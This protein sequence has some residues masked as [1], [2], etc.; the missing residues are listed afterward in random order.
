[1]GPRIGNEKAPEWMPKG[2]R[3]Y[4]RVGSRVTCNPPPVETDEDWLIWAPSDLTSELTAGGFVVEGLPGFYTGN[5]NGNFVS[6]RRAEINAITTPDFEWYRK[7]CRATALAK[8]FNLMLKEDRIALF[9]V[10]LYEVEPEN[11][12]VGSDCGVDLL[13]A[14]R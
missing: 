8:R 2:A 9:Q 7:F 3:A 11:L 5:D 6:F 13:D 1:M 12:A 10:I 14:M 4:R